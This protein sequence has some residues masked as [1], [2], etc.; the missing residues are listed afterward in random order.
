M[1]SIQ[2]TDYPA[3]NDRLSFKR[4]RQLLSQNR[5]LTLGFGASVTV[6]TMIPGINLFVMPAAVCG[7]SIMWA[8][9]LGC[10]QP[11]A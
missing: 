11:T 8:E 2:Y 4:L 6:A 1:M 9:C 7:A 5:V 3:D 10:E